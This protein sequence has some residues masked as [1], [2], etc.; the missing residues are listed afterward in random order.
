MLVGMP[1][2]QMIAPVVYLERGVMDRGQALEETSATGGEMLAEVRFEKTIYRCPSRAR[3]HY[4]FDGQAWNCWGRELASLCVGEGQTPRLAR[5]DWHQRFH[6][7][8][9]RLYAM[10]PFEMTPDE[11]RN[12]EAILSIVDVV[13]YRLST[14]L[15]IREIGCV[16][17]PRTPYPSQMR[18]IDGRREGF[19]L[20]QVPAE[21]AGCKPGQW[22]EAIVEREPL[23]GRL[24]HI[25]HVQRIPSPLPESPRSVRAAWEK[26][27]Q[28]ELPEA[29]WDWPGGG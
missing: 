3:L 26:M 17:Y 5:E 9:Q 21:L 19:S 20:H 15:S 16:R 27:R 24:I 14:P 23:T 25:V 18:W 22:V 2:P 1:S 29:E 4:R 11:S 28:A 8:F 13:D 7:E 6:A 10:R 12:W